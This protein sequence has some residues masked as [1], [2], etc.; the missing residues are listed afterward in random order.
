MEENASKR[1]Q[2]GGCWWEPPASAGGATLQ[3]RGKKSHFDQSGFSPGLPLP[4]VIALPLECCLH[5]KK[6]ARSSPRIAWSLQ[7]QDLGK[8]V[9]SPLVVC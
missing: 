9:T 1:N 5:R 3:R 8:I 7:P 6:L 2:V 4:G